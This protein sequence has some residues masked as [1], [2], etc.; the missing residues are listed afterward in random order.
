MVRRGVL[1]RQERCAHTE[2]RT[3]MRTA[4]ARLGVRSASTESRVAGLGVSAEYAA[5]MCEE[6]EEYS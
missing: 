3:C 4:H 1:I 2:T 5:S 6:R